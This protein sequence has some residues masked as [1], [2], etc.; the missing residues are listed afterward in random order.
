MHSLHGREHGDAPAGNVA[1]RIHY[2]R[3]YNKRESTRLDGN[4]E[5]ICNTFLVEVLDVSIPMKMSAH[6]YY[7]TLLFGD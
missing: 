1:V 4:T 2:F 6:F 3:D 5:N 7:F